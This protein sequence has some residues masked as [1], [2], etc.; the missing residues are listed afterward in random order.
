MQPLLLAGP[1]GL[2]K[3]VYVKA[4]A[5]VL[6]VPHHEIDG[7]TLTAGF[8]LSGLDTGYTSGKAGQVWDALQHECMSPCVTLDEIDKAPAQSAYPALG[9]LFA[10]L[11]T[12]SAQRFR[13][14]AIGLAVDAS[15]ISWIATCND[16][17]ALDGA[18][19]SRF[20]IFHI[21][22]PSTGEMAAVVDSVQRSLA[23]TAS[24]AGSFEPRLRENV[25]PSIS[26]WGTLSTWAMALT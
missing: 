1:P 14:G 8:A 11:E 23:A 13:D 2:G 7:A 3:T 10:L 6:R 21:A 17:A 24:W 12:H 25:A 4:M 15:W 22:M 26:W 9:C 18:L 19:L 16:L 20:E 5:Q